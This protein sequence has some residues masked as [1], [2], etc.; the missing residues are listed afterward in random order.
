MSELDL[1]RGLGD[2]LVPP[3]LDS[4]RETARQR[5]RRTASASL[6]ATFVVAL[7]LTGALV[8]LRDDPAPRPVQ[9][10]GP[11]V[12]DTRP[13]TY[14]EGATVHYGDQTLTMAGEVVELDLTDDGVTVRTDDN[15]MWFTDGSAIHEISAIGESGGGDDET[16]G[17]DVLWG[18]YVGRVVSGN[19]GSEVAW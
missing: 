1:L 4:L 9:P 17:G 2:Q 11:V 5:T 12:D 8:S 10:V 7:G 13:L 19:S 18:T 14:A 6:V 15:R 3:P 16:S